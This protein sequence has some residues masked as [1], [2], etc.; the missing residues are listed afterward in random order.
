MMRPVDRIAVVLVAAMSAG[1]VGAQQ[2]TPEPLTRRWSVRTTFDAGVIPDE[3]STRCGRGAGGTLGAG[4]GFTVVRRAR[5][6][7]ALEEDTHA[8]IGVLPTGCRLDLPLVVIGP[9]VYE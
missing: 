5:S 8:M 6:G 4:L 3:F 7:L 1:A 2:S 9:G